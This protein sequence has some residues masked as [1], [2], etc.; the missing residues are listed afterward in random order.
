[1]DKKNIGHIKCLD[2]K[3]YIV[4]F[5]KYPNYG[6]KLQNFALCKIL[7]KLGFNPITVLARSNKETVLFYLKIF[8][9]FL[10]ILTDKQNIWKN[11]RKKIEKFKDFN[12][13]L[14][15]KSFSYRELSAQRFRNE[16]AIV[17]S[18]QVWSPHHLVKEKE[19]IKLFFLQFIEE[20]KRIAYAPSFGVEKISSEYNYLYENNI[21]K[22][23]ALSVR[24]ESGRQIISGICNI[25][26][27]QVVPDPVFLLSKEEW[28]NE[29][30]DIKLELCNDDYILVY[31]LSEH[32]DKVWNNIKKYS[33]VKK[34]KII[35][36]SGNM[37]KDG[38]LI[39]TPNEFIYFLN[40]AKVV[41]T[42]SFHG[43]AFSILFEKMFLVL[44]RSDVAQFTRIDN[45]LCKYK[46]EEQ[47]CS[48]YDLNE[49]VIK[50]DEI[51][52]IFNLSICKNKERNKGINFLK[53]N[54]F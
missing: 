5:C 25:D 20:N 29:C 50:L 12:K 35:S 30:K 3:V 23:K 19:N 9:S 47:K 36:I 33:R 54:L 45:L 8:L 28:L 48:C 11:L 17:G 53:K 13:C 18:D 1:M 6:S 40:N 4:T 51:Y 31:F 22:F 42:D 16:F 7:R 34:L 38:D 32:D 39:V 46:L 14:N 41:I 43:V 15:I 26:N 10:P 37:Y 49:M 52:D 21:N 44:V 24:E 27:V 2:K